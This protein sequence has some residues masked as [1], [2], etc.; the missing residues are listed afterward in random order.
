MQNRVIFAVLVASLLL[1]YFVY[2]VFIDDDQS[3]SQLRT[4]GKKLADDAYGELAERVGAELEL[5]F[6]ELDSNKDGVL[7]LEEFKDRRLAIAA[8]MSS[9]RRNLQQN[10]DAL[11]RISLTTRQQVFSFLFT[12]LQLQLVVL[13]AFVVFENVHYMLID[14]K[15]RVLRL[16]NDYIDAAVP[17]VDVAK[18]LI[19]DTPMTLYERAKMAFMIVSGIA[20][21][22]VILIICFLLFG[23]FFLNVAVIGGRNRHKN[24]IWFGACES[25]VQLAGNLIFVSLGFYCIRVYGHPASVD[26]VK[27][28]AGNHICAI[29]TLIL[30]FQANM[31]SFI[32]RVENLAIPGFKAVSQATRSILVN[33]DAATSRKQTMEAICE[34][35]KSKD[36]EANRIMLFP[37]G[38][39]NNQRA[40]FT[41]KRGAFEPG[42]PVQLVA[43]AFPYKHFNVCW[44]GRAAGGNDF[45]DFFLRL[46]CQFVNHAEVRFL[47]VYYP[48]AAERDNAELYA[49]HAQR[50]IAHVARLPVSDAT[51][52]N[53]KDLEVAYSKRKHD[54]NRYTFIDGNELDDAKKN[55]STSSTLTSVSTTSSSPSPSATGAAVAVSGS[56]TP[57]S[58]VST[59][60]SPSASAS[61]AAAA[62]NASSPAHEKRE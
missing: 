55:E 27:I 37:E 2:E 20:L 11:P 28:V 59:E 21:L 50:M 61:A 9:A 12:W 34:R 47:P 57:P 23:V 33:R 31:P 22:R 56:S 40:L 1:A 35:A 62:V 16:D 39:C 17:K 24:K 19:Y 15:P 58:G 7:S 14:P 46:V 5:L 53:Y 49:A 41:F 43:F 32:S 30:F 42:E 3:V 13:L 44:N 48:S 52:Q 4:Y 25:M 51:F 38:T 6:K 45:F 26:E 54:K 10:F 29:E 36:P 60:T 8:A 18:A